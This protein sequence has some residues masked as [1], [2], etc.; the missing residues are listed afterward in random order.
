[1]ALIVDAGPIYA[2]LN[3]DDPD[4]ARCRALLDTF[5][6]PLIV[7]APVLVETEYLART[8]I[9]VG[10]SVAFLEDVAAGVFQIL[11][12][13]LDD[14]RRVRDICRQYAD[15]AIGLVDAAVLAIAERLDEKKVATI[16]H[17]HFRMFR[18]RHV[19]SLTLLPE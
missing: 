5:T 18:P 3:R 11:D 16:D 4:H 19:D 8:R 17:R 6:E 15:A 7:P 12:L 13:T 14:Y 10:M 2:S 9:G 1:V